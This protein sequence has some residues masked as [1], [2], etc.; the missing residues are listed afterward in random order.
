MNRLIV[1]VILLSL[2]P[3]NPSTYA[4]ET[5]QHWFDLGKEAYLENDW[6]YCVR[7]MELAIEEFNKYKKSMNTCRREC[8]EEL[9]SNFAPLMKEDV[10][11]YHF[12][13]KKVKTT[14]CLVTQCDAGYQQEQVPQAVLDELNYKVPFN[15]L[16]ICYHKVK[17]VF[18]FHRILVLMVVQYCYC[19]WTTM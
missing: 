13:E 4:S 10:N 12:Y 19:S 15:Y 18:F 11:D 7:Y 3:V 14:L 2:A 8:R 1:G 17:D 5:F 9:D 16:Q 6:D